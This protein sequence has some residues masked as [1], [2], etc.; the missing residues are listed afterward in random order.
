MIT[1]QQIIDKV[2]RITENA[3]YVT[4]GEDID[5]YLMMLEDDL[6]HVDIECSGFDPYGIPVPGSKPGEYISAAAIRLIQIEA[7][8]VCV[9]FDMKYLDTVSREKI[10]DYLSEPSRILVF[11][12]A[13]F[14][15]KWLMRHLGVKFH[16]VYCTMIASQLLSQ[17]QVKFG[18]SLKAIVNNYFNYDLD[19]TLGAS[20]WMHK[21]LT[22][23]QIIYASFDAT[24]LRPIRIHQIQKLKEQGQMEVA[25]IE[26]R[27]LEPY[28]YMEL[29][30]IKLHRDRWLRNAIR[31]KY[32]AIRMEEKVAKALAPEG[33]TGMLFDNM[34]N[35]KVSS[36]QQLTAAMK[37]AGI[38]V[39]TMIKKGTSEQKETIQVDYLE[40]IADTHP[41]IPLIIKYSTLK[42]SHTSYG[43]N[44]ID[45]INPVT[46]RI[47][48]DIFQIG[49][50]TGRNSFKEPNLQQVPVENIYRNCFI[51]EPGNKLV[52]GDYV[53]FELRIIAH[54]SGDRAMIN[55][56]NKGLDLHTYTASVVFRVPYEEMMKNKN[57]VDMK[58]LRTRAKNLNFGIVYGIGAKR[59]AKNANITEAEAYNIIREYFALYEGLK[60]WL[61]WA[62]REASQNHTS[63]TLSG[64]KIYHRFDKSDPFWK[65]SAAERL[66]T[67]F[68]IQGTNAD[69]AKI[70]L[71]N[72][73]D[74]LGG[75]VKLV[76]IIHDEILIECK[77]EEAVEIQPIFEQCMIKAGEAYITSVPILVE[78]SIMSRWSK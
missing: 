30:G 61:D 62:K 67:N 46:Q 31:N 34:S 20:D 69:I 60:E 2:V 36:T 75:R 25:N 10:R 22:P 7:N 11:Q 47:H 42:K 72:V 40:K 33:D 48:P 51:T 13:K 1:Q 77:E 56:F 16:K 21:E 78:S 49:T 43:Q 9:N 8:D 37:R 27:A 76:N 15:M 29:C 57:N 32:R 4:T 58:I 64:R 53:A 14:D 5:S 63:K 26:F 71:R 54:A 38:N 68:P 12:N 23:Q 50:E 17:G 35:F 44:W 74:E 18:H 28:A 19:K 3:Y 41:A 24:F 6:T 73:Y 52:G 66:G 39:P 70:A 59:F 45:K 65:I 55:A